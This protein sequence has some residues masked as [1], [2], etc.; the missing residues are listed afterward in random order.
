MTTKP[1]VE[2]PTPEPVDLK[3]PEPD[4][5]RVRERAYLIWVEEGKP[6]GRE[7]DHWLRAKWELKKEDLKEELDRLEHGLACAGKAD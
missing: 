2:V 4:D 5:R 7:L 6:E 1:S 3:A